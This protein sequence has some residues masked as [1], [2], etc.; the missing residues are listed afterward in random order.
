MISRFDQLFDEDMTASAAW[1]CHREEIIEQNP[2]DYHLLLGKCV[3]YDDG[4][5]GKVVHDCV[6]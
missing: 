3:H 1:H 2:Q 5:G 6:E 4:K